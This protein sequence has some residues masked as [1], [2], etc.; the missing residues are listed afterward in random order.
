[1]KSFICL[2]GII[3]SVSQISIFS[4]RINGK[5]VVIN[6]NNIKYT[7]LLQINTN[8]GIDDLGGTTIVFGFDTSAISFPSNAIRDVD[9]IFHNFNGGNYSS[10]SITKPTNDKIWVNINL[11]FANSNNGTIVAQSPTWTDVVTLNFDIVNHNITPNLYWYLTSMFW[12]IYDADNITLWETGTFEG[13]FGLAVEVKDGWNMVSAPGTIPDG[14]GVGTWWEHKT[15]TVWGFNGSQYVAKDVATTG[16]GYWMS[17]NG[18]NL[19]NT[20]DEWPA[21]GIQKVP[22][23]PVNVSAG[24]NLIGGYE[25]IVQTNQITSTPVGLI[26]GPFYTYSDQYQIVTALEPGCGYIVKL[27]GQGTINFPNG[28]TKENGNQVDYFKDEWGKI[29]FSDNSNRIFTLYLVNCDIDLSLYELPPTPPEKL[30]DIRF[31]SGRIVEKIGNEI[32]FILMSGV[33]YPVKVMVENI[34]IRLQD[35]SGK[36]IDTE[37]YS[38]EEITISNEAITKLKVVSDEF[39]HPI[40][41]V[42][43]QNYPNPFNPSTKISFTIPVD[44]NVDLSIYNALG[45][46]VSNMVSEHLLAGY[47]EYQFNASKLASGVYFYRIK[48]GDLVLTKK[49]VLI[50]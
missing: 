45:E 25:K 26:A 3:F 34:N 37:L 32:K 42:M 30:F 21:S 49:M 48:A 28:L 47:H 27:N 11:P 24:W 2:L 14:M 39:T 9:Y 16:E 46:L 31:G 22:N 13:N 20:G 43:M 38:D 1:M 8:T 33:D 17:N 4:T 6:T 18:N 19:Y 35:E 40:D 41:L 23:T 44:A 29:I 50:R 10:A 36:I 12:G 5:F 7:V 15:G